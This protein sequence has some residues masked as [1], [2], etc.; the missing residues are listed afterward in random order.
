[1]RLRDDA[2][3]L[4]QLA[5]RVS[6]T[7]DVVWRSKAA[8]LYRERAAERAHGL[9][10]S[11]TELEEAARLVDVH[12]GGVEAARAEVVRVAGLGADLARVASGAVTRVV[13]RP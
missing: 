12:A 1:M 6:A 3:R 2:D 10:V 5:R 4:R 8:T 11:A 7:R 9:Q 13:A